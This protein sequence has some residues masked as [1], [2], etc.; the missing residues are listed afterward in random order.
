MKS[1]FQK[2]SLSLIAV[3]AMLS[4]FVHAASAVDSYTLDQGDKVHIYVF[5]EENL[6]IS[7]TLTD[8]GKISYPFLGEVVARGLTLSQLEQRIA[9]GLKG[10][11]LIN[12]KV[13][14]TIEEYRPFFVQGEVKKPGRY[15]YQPGI[16]L[17]KALAVAGGINLR[18][19]AKRIDVTSSAGSAGK[20]V[21][22]TRRAASLE[23]LI[24]PGDVISVGQRVF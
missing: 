4:P 7:V 24:Q 9:Q 17:L 22:N 8:E 15:A 10:R 14:I 18:G 6:S 13:N 21:S 12:P 16:N 11:F 20:K 1:I 2:V 5:R 3:L 23:I 19:S